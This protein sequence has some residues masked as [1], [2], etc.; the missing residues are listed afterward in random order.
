MKTIK[1]L[2]GQMMIHEKAYQQTKDFEEF[3]RNIY[4]MILEIE[5]ITPITPFFSTYLFQV[6][7]DCENM[8]K[9][10]IGNV[11]T[12]LETFMKRLD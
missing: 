11:I 9:F 1:E 5:K 6:K 7:M 2:N 4:E 10:N 3:R 8:E 12:S